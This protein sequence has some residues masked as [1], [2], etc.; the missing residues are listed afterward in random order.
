[1]VMPVSDRLKEQVYGEAYEARVAEEAA[2]AALASEAP[3][4]AICSSD[5]AYPE[6]V[7][8][9]IE[10]IK[11]KRPETTVVLAGRPAKEHEATYRDAGLDHAIYLGSNCYD[12]LR[13]LQVEKGVTDER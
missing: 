11:A 2:G 4:V 5:A 1:M 3:I 7:P 10:R 9:I 6:V 8:P 13:T 12:L